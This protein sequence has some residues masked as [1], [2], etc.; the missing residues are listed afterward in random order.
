[1]STA[2]WEPEPTGEGLMAPQRRPS[3]Q[4]ASATLPVDAAHRSGPR[5]RLQLHDFSTPV[6]ATSIAPL[7]A[8]AA[9][10]VAT[11]A[12]AS[13]ARPAFAARLAANG[14]VVA[15]KNHFGTALR[16]V[17]LRNFALLLQPQVLLQ[18][19]MALAGLGAVVMTVATLIVSGEQDAKNVDQFG[20]A[21]AWTPPTIAAP[22]WST[23]AQPVTSAP[24]ATAPAEMPGPATSPPANAS[25][26]VSLEADAPVWAPTSA[27]PALPSAP[28]AAVPNNPTT[29]VPNVAGLATP[30]ANANMQATAPREPEIVASRPEAPRPYPATFAP[31]KPPQ[32]RITGNI[33]VL[34]G[35]PTP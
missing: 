21:P 27:L 2:P 14:I 23:V 26:T 17:L 20:A 33:T 31:E 6:P 22:D 30:A 3:K 1:M 9:T 10:T 4:I 35:E 24:A 32:A 18:P 13:P 7:A 11:T 25:S 16:I 8:A 19:K 29:I 12:E 34:P 28:P 5:L 15:L